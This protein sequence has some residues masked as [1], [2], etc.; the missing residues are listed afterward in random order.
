MSDDNVIHVDFGSNKKEPDSKDVT[1]NGGEDLLKF[2]VFSA[3]I[4]EGLV[5]V[6]LDARSEGV[7]VPD[8]HA[9]DSKLRLDF[10]F[11]FGVPDF[12]FDEEGVRASLSFSGQDIWCDIPWSSVYMLGSQDLGES[13]IF[14][15]SLPEDEYG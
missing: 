5:R 1:P 11:M 12:S 15:D 7:I 14:P 4:Q 9:N 6:I 3:W 8:K 13:V 2:K 10:C